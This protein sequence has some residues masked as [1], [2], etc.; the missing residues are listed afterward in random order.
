M[1]VNSKRIVKCTFMRGAFLTAQSVKN[2]SAMQETR[3]MSPDPIPGSGRSLGGGN[4]NSLQY[5][6]LENPID[7]GAWGG[8]VGLQSMALQ[9]I[10]HDWVTNTFMFQDHNSCEA[11]VISQKPG[12]PPK[13]TQPFFTPSPADPQCLAPLRRPQRLWTIL[14]LWQDSICYSSL[15]PLPD[16]NHVFV[17]WNYFSVETQ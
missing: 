2:L 3:E 5:S 16:A 11:A 8:G 14:A 9:R 17:L 1:A 7:R 15:T 6:C 4:G 12:T 10:G 13:L